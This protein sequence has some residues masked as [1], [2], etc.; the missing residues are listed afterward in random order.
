MLVRLLG[1][2]AGGGCPQW[3]CRCANCSDV[4]SGAG[5]VVPRLQSGVALS[6]NGNDWFLINASPDIRL[7]IESFTPLLPQIGTV[8]GSSIA[9]VLL[10][11]A[12]LD[13]TLGLFQL[14]EGAPLNV[15]AT[16]EVRTSLDAGLAFS[17]VM[18]TY[19]GVSWHEPPSE[20]QPLLLP[21]GDK[22]DLKYRAIA[23][24]GDAPKYIKNRDNK[25]YGHSVGYSII[26]TQSGGKLLF[27]P[28]VSTLENIDLNDCDLLLFDG[29]FWSNDEMALT[30]TGHSTAEQ[31][32]HIPIGGARG[33]LSAL[34]QLTVRRR[35]YFHINNTNPILNEN[36]P[37]HGEVT[38]A[39]V[40]IGY[41]GLEFTV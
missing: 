41:D 25:T 31:M 10:T 21:S 37:E 30:G 2:A 8:R 27:L 12:D 26:D 39:G 16:P 20:Y 13:H 6:A 33:S 4:R 32:G 9:G 17:A 34:K 40:E 29:T 19:C 14:R 35:V 23:I 36:S 24:A 38:A 3:N 22:S 1:T 18:G 28:D 7:Q 11:N 5:R 15:H